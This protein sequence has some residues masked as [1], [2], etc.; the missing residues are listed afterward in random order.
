MSLWDSAGDVMSV[1]TVRRHSENP[2]EEE[3][4]HF[5]I[6]RVLCLVMSVRESHGT[7]WILAF[8]QIQLKIIEHFKYKNKSFR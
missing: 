7:E 3:K 6:K 8:S 5:N 4:L 1:S 2:G